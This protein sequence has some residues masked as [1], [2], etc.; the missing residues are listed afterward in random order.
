MK[1]TIESE[2]EA[3][4]RSEKEPPSKNFWEYEYQF[5]F[6]YGWHLGY[7]EAMILVSFLKIRNKL[8]DNDEEKEI[9]QTIASYAKNIRKLISSR[10]I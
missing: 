1:E 4:G 3:I 10:K 5:D 8:P 6:E 9:K 7:L 2:L